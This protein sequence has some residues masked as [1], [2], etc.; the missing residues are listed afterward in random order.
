MELFVVFQSEDNQLRCILY[1]HMV[2]G[3]LVVVVYEEER[4]FED[5][6]S[7]KT[8]GLSITSAA[9]NTLLTTPTGFLLFVFR[10]K[11]AKFVTVKHFEEDFDVLGSLNRTPP[12]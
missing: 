8:T 2:C 12:T 11:C 5:T 7:A 1:I 4:L 9:C 6:R 10:A 3:K